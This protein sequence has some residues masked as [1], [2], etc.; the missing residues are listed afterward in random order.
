MLHGGRQRRDA[1]G[2]IRDE[3]ESRLSNKPGTIAMD[4]DGGG[5]TAG[6]AFFFNVEHNNFLDWFESD[7]PSAHVVFGSVDDESLS[8]LL[9]LS[10][11]PTDDDGAP[12]SQV[13]VNRLAVELN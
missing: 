13:R 2:G 11:V 12:L 10:R 7:T 3:F 6:G 8:T 9:A 4:S 1:A 5:G